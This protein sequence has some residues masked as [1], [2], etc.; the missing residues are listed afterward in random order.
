MPAPNAPGH[1]TSHAPAIADPRVCDGAT[2]SAGISA[3]GKPWQD[4]WLQLSH[5]LRTPL[6]GILGN[7]ELLLD[8][9]AGPL[10]APARACVGDIQVASRQLLRQL[11]PL[12]QLVQA[13]TVGAIASGP[14]IDLLELLRQ[15]AADRASGAPQACAAQDADA[16]VRCHQPRLPEDVC[17]TVPGDPVW[18]GALAAALL[19]LPAGR[20]DAPRPLSI[21]LEP[22]DRCGEEAEKRPG[23]SAGG[24]VICASWPGLEPA[25]VCPLWLALIDAILQ[26]HEGQICSLSA[27]G[28]RLHLPGAAMV[29]RNV[30]A[31][32]RR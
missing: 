27:E 25:A 20:V 29:R 28:L 12:L 16:G 10:T 17:L 11:Q 5:E 4:D 7:I 32:G 15:A 31:R 24:I 19:N 2:A 9:T 26:L 23:E 14:R 13:R 3:G 6:N 30:S 21:T 18:L 22:P 8:G 1:A